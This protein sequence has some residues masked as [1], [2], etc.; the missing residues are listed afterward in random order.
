MKK[1]L[2]LIVFALIVVCCKKP[3]KYPDGGSFSLS[4]KKSRVANSWI[5]GAV[6]Q[7]DED[8][9]SHFKSKFSKYNIVI[10]KSGSYGALY[11]NSAGASVVETGKWTLTA[12]NTKIA[13]TANTGIYEWTILRLKQKELWVL[14]THF[15]GTK[16]E[17]H[18]VP[19]D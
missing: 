9:T 3:K 5:V 14:D 19:Y 1:F 15:K 17:I 7:E 4:S 12:K 8:T 16:I 2:L 11:Y 13:F 10:N 6:Y 18:F